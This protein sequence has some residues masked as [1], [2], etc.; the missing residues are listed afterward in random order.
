VTLDEL[1]SVIMPLE[2]APKGALAEA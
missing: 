1:P 2:P